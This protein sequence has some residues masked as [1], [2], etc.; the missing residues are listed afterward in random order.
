MT[1]AVLFFKCCLSS[2]VGPCLLP[3]APVAAMDG[4]VVHVIRDA[5]LDCGQRQVGVGMGICVWLWCLPCPVAGS[6]G[7]ALLC[8]AA[9]CRIGLGGG[10]LVYSVLC[11]ANVLLTFLGF[12]GRYEFSQGH[13][14]A[15]FVDGFAG[16]VDDRVAVRGSSVPA[17]EQYLYPELSL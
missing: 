11:F 7:I 9:I 3:V 14:L 12:S 16:V 6:G 15:A 4:L 13:D 5:D 10:G 2:G 1:I 17:V 8:F